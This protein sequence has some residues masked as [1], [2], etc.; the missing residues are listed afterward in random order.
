MSGVIFNDG[1]LDAQATVSL[2]LTA[3]TEAGARFHKR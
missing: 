3:Q 1:K 2:Q